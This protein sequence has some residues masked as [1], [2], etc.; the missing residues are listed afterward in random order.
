MVV[1]LEEK[2]PD[3]DILRNEV[4]ETQQSTDS[5][6]RKEKCTARKAFIILSLQLGGLVTG[7]ENGR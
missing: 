7:R 5:G 2:E 3:Q 1:Y 4:E 6:W